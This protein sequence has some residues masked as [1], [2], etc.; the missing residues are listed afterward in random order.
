MMP[1]SSSSQPPQATLSQVQSQPLP[2]AGSFATPA[3]NSDSRV[4]KAVLITVA[5]FVGLAVIGAGVIGF[6]V[7]YLAKSVQHVPSATFTESDLGIAIY[8]GAEPSMRGSRAEIAGK[9]M[10]SA[11]YFTQDSTDKVMAFY[12][13]KAGPNAQP[14][15]TRHSSGFRLVEATGEV[16]TVS[17]RRV[18]DKSGGET[19][20]AITH[21]TENAAS[22]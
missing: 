13:E 4:V 1:D 22:H 18:S 6:G 16:T 20:I 9:T 10:L 19:Y 17:V 15:T 21:L 3:A 8:P 2:P 12:K 11:A 14:I 7:W 5:V